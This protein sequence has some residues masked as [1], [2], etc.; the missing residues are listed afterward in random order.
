L[1]FPQRQLQSREAVLYADLTCSDTGDLDW[2][3]PHSWGVTKIDFG[4]RSIP[5]RV[6]EALSRLGVFHVAGLCLIADIW[7]AIAFTEFED[8]ETAE[9]LILA[10]IE[11]LE[12][13]HLI[14][15][16]A[17]NEDV[18][19]LYRSWQWPMYDFEFRPINISLID[20]KEEQERHFYSN[21]G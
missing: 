21:F 11:G 6:A 1:D 16:A 10:T 13:R 5:L 8:Y 19:I 12:A 9:G 14:T 7:G 18:Q 2:S 4:F 20:L 3:D 15:E 17:T